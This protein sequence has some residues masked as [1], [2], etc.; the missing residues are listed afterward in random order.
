MSDQQLEKIGSYVKSH[1]PQWLA[2]IAPEQRAPAV[3]DPVLLE[4]IVR[5]EESL[6]HQRELMQQGFQTMDKRFAE[7]RADTNAR[8]EQ[9]DKRFEQID[10]RFEQVDKRFEEMR[11]DMN[12]RFEHVDKRFEQVDKR[13]EDMRTD[14]NTRFEEM[15]ADMNTRFEEVRTDMNTQFQQVDK[16]FEDMHTSMDARFRTTNRMIV[17]FFA[18]VTVV[19]AVVQVL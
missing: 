7:M 9:V 19:S 6:S 18:L 16:R 14:M 12:T 5:V 13:F 4:R 10:K 2:E 1:L 3:S 11:T 15:R 17:A 8:F